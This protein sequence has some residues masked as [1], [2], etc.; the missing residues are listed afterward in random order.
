MY[1]LVTNSVYEEILIHVES[2]VSIV[3]HGKFIHVHTKNETLESIYIRG[4]NE[5]ALK[6]KIKEWVTEC[7]EEEE[8]LLGLGLGLL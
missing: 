6:Q 4:L 1:L 2:V 8:D 3:P 5:D 7:F